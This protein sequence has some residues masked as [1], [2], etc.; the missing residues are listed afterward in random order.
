M[1]LDLLPI[2]I[3]AISTTGFRRN[4]QVPSSTT[5]STSLYEIDYLLKK[6]LANEADNLRV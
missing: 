4:L 2:D 3:T 6:E 5:F 1:N